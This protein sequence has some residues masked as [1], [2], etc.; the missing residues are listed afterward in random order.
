[1]LGVLNCAEQYKCKNVKTK[2]HNELLTQEES[3]CTYNLAQ[4]PEAVCIMC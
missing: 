3:V 2:M 4:K 1:M